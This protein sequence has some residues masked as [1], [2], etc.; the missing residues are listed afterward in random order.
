MQ[1]LKAFAG[2]DLSFELGDGFALWLETLESR[3]DIHIRSDLGKW[4]NA[5]YKMPRCTK[6]TCEKNKFNKIHQQM[7]WLELSSI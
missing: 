1:N 3:Y 5:V 7:Q 4:D 6:R 2:I